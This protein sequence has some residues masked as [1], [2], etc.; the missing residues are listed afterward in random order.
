MQCTQSG[1]QDYMFKSNI[2]YRRD[3]SSSGACAVCHVVIPEYCMD[4]N[5][6]QGDIAFIAV[7][8]N[9]QPLLIKV[10]CEITISNT[11]FFL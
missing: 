6:E 5:P 4:M 7:I 2:A 8:R 10:F 9:Q 11:N 3:R 1:K